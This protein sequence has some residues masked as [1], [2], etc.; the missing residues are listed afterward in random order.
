LAVRCAAEELVAL[1]GLPLLADLPCG[2]C[3]TEA[4]RLAD[5]VRQ[6]M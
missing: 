3:E 5:G 4:V 6:V 1:T 2:L